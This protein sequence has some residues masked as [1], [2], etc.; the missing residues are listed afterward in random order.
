MVLKLFDW[1]ER[2]QKV[3]R[4]ALSF[5]LV[6]LKKPATV[7]ENQAVQLR[8]TAVSVG[9]DGKTKNKTKQKVSIAI[10]KWRNSSSLRRRGWVPSLHTLHTLHTLGVPFKFKCIAYHVHG[11]TAEGGRHD[12][13][14]QEAGESEIRCKSPKPFLFKNKAKS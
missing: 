13:V 6:I 3:A 12:A 1:S 2:I 9:R 8:D 11:R 10:E 5:Q 7:T 4:L 14:L